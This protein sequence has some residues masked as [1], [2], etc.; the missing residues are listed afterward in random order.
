MKKYKSTFVNMGRKGRRF[1]TLLWIILF[2][3]SQTFAQR[4]PI[5]NLL[6]ENIPDIAPSLMERWDQ[7]QNIRSASFA[8][9]DANGGMYIVTRFADVAQLHHVKNAGAYREQVTF[10]KEPITSAKVSPNAANDGF[11]FSKDQ[12]GNENYQ[13]YFFDRKTGKNKLLTDGKSRNGNAIWNHNGDKIAFS[14]NKRDGKNIDFYIMDFKNPDAAQLLLQNVGGGWSM[15]DWSDDDTKMIIRNGISANESKLFVFDLASKKV[16]EI[17]PTTKQIAYRD[18]AFADNNRDIWFVNDEAGEYNALYYYSNSMKEA[19]KIIAPEGEIE[20]LVFSHNRKNFVYVVNEKGYSTAYLYD[21]QNVEQKKLQTPAGVIGNL[22]FDPKDERIALSIVTPTSPSDVY[23]FDIKKQT[24]ERWT[25]SETGGLNP[26]NFVTCSLINFPTFDT[27]EA[28]KKPRMIPSFMFKSRAA[29]PGGSLG[30]LPVIID[31]H[32]GPEGQSLPNFSNS[33]Q[34]WANEL[35]CVVLVPNVRGSTGYGKTYLKLDNG[36]LR[37]NSVKDIGALLDWIATQPDLDASRVAVYGGSYGGYMSLACMTNFN[38]RLKCGVDLF[39]ISNFVT[40]LKN[41]SGY[42]VDLRRV[43]YGDE[44]DPAMAQILER[45]SPL[46][47]IK[48]I[49]KPMFIFQGENDP[50][51]PLSESEQMLAS[52]KT[53]G[54]TTWYV[55][56]KDEGHGIAKKANRDYTYAAMA[57]FLQK[58]LVEK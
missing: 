37:E 48:N 36:A 11:L 53:N 42:R 4:K 25:F 34:F 17:H 1:S 2:V 20:S 22:N 24:S 50:R 44:R 21:T 16:E 3:S 58:F 52:L 7:Y 51:V 40:F 26:D 57:A 39:G 13:I 45:I 5:G 30:K 19:T 38:A 55:R 54:V 10:S 15:V 32:G 43:E 46:T 47:N 12:G 41:T 18:A 31:I 35:G 28:T 14:S 29:M 27:D 8:D 9:W 23:V 56:A 33:R 6:T 49:T